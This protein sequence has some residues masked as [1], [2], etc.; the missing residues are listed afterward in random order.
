MMRHPPVPRAL[1]QVLDVGVGFRVAKR[2]T[3]LDANRRHLR[4]VRCFFRGQIGQRGHKPWIFGI[5]IDERKRR[6][7][8]LVLT[9]GVIHQ[10]FV[11]IV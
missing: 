4:K 1:Q 8:S 5:P 7:G 6:H 9:V 11:E 3:A 2:Q 10:N